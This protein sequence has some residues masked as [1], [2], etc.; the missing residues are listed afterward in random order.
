MVKKTQDKILFSLSVILIFVVALFIFALLNSRRDEDSGN[1]E[2]SLISPKNDSI[3]KI[4]ESERKSKYSLNDYYIK[5]KYLDEKINEI[6][7]NLSEDERIGQLIVTA[8]GKYGKPYSE[9][10]KL[11]EKKSIGGV[12]MLKGNENEFKSQITK[13]RDIAKERKSLPLIFSCDAEP[14]L[15]NNKIEG[16]KS[17]K[18]T[19]EIKTKEDARKTGEEISKYIK[20]LGFNQNFAP[21]CDLNINKEIIGDRSFGSDIKKVAELANEFIKVTQENNL[22]ATAKHFPGHG[23]V[24]G[25]SHKN[26][27][28]INGDLKELEVFE[29]V[30]KEGKVISVMVGHIAIKGNNEYNTDNKP[31]TISRKIVTNLLKEKIGFEGIVITDAMNMEGVS[32]LSSP[33]LNA[34]LAGCDMIMMPSDVGVLITSVK[35]KMKENPGFSAQIEKSIK[36]IIK[37]KICLGLI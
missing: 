8:A 21:V 3:K 5:D 33:S 12:L 6:Y 31:A 34:L 27:V 19:S 4:S 28:F 2:D 1:K 30:I 36:K 24:K 15:L 23:N 11:I 7:K 18:K 26:L 37:L 32:K 22:V 20:S 10:T 25:D 16:S 14:S 35:E 9:V 29:R 17:F 13:F